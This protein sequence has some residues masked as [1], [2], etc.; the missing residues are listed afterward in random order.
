MLNNVQCYFHNT[1]SNNLSEIIVYYL[2]LILP[3]NQFRVYTC[4]VHPLTYVMILE[5]HVHQLQ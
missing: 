2:D 5:I 1:I 3:V 4:L